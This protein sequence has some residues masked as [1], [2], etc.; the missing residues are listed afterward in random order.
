MTSDSE[1]DEIAQD[2][3]LLLPRNKKQKDN[4]GDNSSAKAVRKSKYGTLSG[5]AK[6]NIFGEDM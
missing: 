3:D 2:T 5:T 4:I 1:E 6:T